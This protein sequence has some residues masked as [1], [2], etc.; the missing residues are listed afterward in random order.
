MWSRQNVDTLCS[1]RTRQRTTD[2]AQVV[3]SASKGLVKLGGGYGC[4]RRLIVRHDLD[5][6]LLV[7]SGAFVPCVTCCLFL[8]RFLV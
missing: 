6:S 3:S 7:G 4:V 1:R 5:P 2:P 8:S